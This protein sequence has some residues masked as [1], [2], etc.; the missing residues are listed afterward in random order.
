MMQHKGVFAVDSKFEEASLKGVQ[1]GN[2]EKEIEMKYCIRMNLNTMKVIVLSVFTII[3]L[4]CITQHTYDS[5]GSESNEHQLLQE[6]RSSY[7]P[8]PLLISKAGPER[9]TPRTYFCTWGRL[10]GPPLFA[11]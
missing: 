10:R 5:N 9:T 7:L 1:L 6:M 2:Y 11:G 8:H 3:H 4:H